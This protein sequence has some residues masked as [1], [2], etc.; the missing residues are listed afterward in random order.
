[1]PV[2]APQWR[3]TQRM[4]EDAPDC[5]GVYVLWRDGQP[6]AVGHALGVYD[7]IRFRLLAHLAHADSAQL[8][9]T[10]YSWQICANPLEREEELSRQ[11]GLSARPLSSLHND[12]NT[13][14]TP[15]RHAESESS[16]STT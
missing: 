15:C 13:N 11:L 5:Q 9:I 6:L 8:G 10:H 4:V 3:F 1:M 7:T 12:T 14:T 2:T 16:S